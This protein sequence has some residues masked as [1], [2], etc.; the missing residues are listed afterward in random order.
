MQTLDELSRRIAVIEDLG[1]VVRT[2]KALSA[3]SIL[4]YETAA[5]AIGVYHKSIELGLQ[6][7]L[8]SASV[9]LGLKAGAAGGCGAVLFG[10]DHGLCGRFNEVVL[11]FAKSHLHDRNINLET[12][13]W[14]AVGHRMADRL[15]SDECG[16]VQRLDLPGTV[17]GLAAMAGA[18]IVEVDR[19]Q[20]KSGIDRVLVFHNRRAALNR[21]VP[22]VVQLLPADQDYFRQLTHRRW[23]ARGRKR[24][25]SRL[26][27]RA[28]PP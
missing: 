8:Q 11:D 22:V 27:S 19:W 2:M 23:Q 14:L 24:L 13:R 18:A 16:P 25:Q 9:Q 3:V 21:T 17:E 26:L 5:V 6:A 7:V 28:R 15:G 20:R 1:S 4:Q 12:G 10:S